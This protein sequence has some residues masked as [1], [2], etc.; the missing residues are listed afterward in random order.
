MESPTASLTQ[1]ATSGVAWS[2]IFQVSR[3]V[4][5]VISVS[6]LAR[7]VPPSAYGIVSM[8]ATLT[9]FLETFRDLGTTNALVREPKL[10]DNLVSTVFWLNCILGV[11]MSV[12]VFGI[13]VPA[14]RFFHEPALVGVIRTVS[15]VFLLN[16]LAV[17]P[18][19]LLNREMAFR[20]INMASFAGAV[21]GT[22]VAIITAIRGG[23][24]WSL[25]F[26]TLTNT[27]VTTAALWMYCRWRFLWVMRWAE[28]RCIA[29]YT[30][31]LSGFNILNYFSRNADNLIV[32]RFLGSVPLGYYQMAY[33]LMTYP[34]SNFTSVICQVLFPAMS[35]VQGDNARFRRAYVRTCMLISLVT[36]PLM[37][38]LTVTAGPIIVVV[39]G[40]RWLPVA[41]L[42]TV[43]GPLG[44][45][46]SISTTVGLI[47][48]AKG[49]ADWMFRW[50]AVST[51]FFV[52]SFFAGLPWGIMGVAIAYAAMFAI[53]VIPCFAI[54]FRLIELP[55][56]GFLKELWPSLR[57]SLLMAGVVVLWRLGLNKMG[58]TNAPV[59]L[60]SS[61]TVGAISY[62][63]LMLWWKPRVLQ[64]FRDVL[65]QSGNSIALRLT[66]YL[67]A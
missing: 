50:A 49:R 66:R 67:P 15:L 37:L 22:C 11:V 54:P 9:N 47:Y 28:V 39:L 13:A 17:V 12:C 1:K 62:V 21:S 41:G 53:V 35:Q 52:G 38:G 3:Q 43:F 34:L 19:A 65:E 59:E 46:Q 7:H 20:K 29:S 51:L 44:L 60:F 10:T 58:V 6:V 57:A 32:G 24:V 55:L 33:T 16:A 56:W 2:T 48:N 14:S 31:N 26:G 4:L 63:L 5:S 64:E 42:L 23:G 25:V 18:T 30:L 36:F 45:I 61:I 8:A 40:K 27:A